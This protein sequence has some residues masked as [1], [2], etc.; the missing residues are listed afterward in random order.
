MKLLIINDYGING[1]GTE[2]RIKQLAEFLFNSH[3]FE[4]IHIIEH[5]T[6]NSQHL[7][8]Q[9]HKLN[10]KK[11]EEEIKKIII[12]YAI[13]HVQI[14]N[15]TL[16]PSKIIK[17]I[18]KY[19]LPIIF[20]AHDYWGFCGRRNLTTANQQICKGF[21]LT[22]CLPC[23]GVFSIIHLQKIKQALNL[24]DVGIAP[25]SYVQNIYENH[26]I[27]KNKWVI[28]PPW[29]DKEI[30][31][32]HKKQ[33]K[34]KVILFVG[35]L[36]YFK[37]IDLLLESISIIKDQLNQFEIHIVG[38][39]QDKDNKNRIRI[40]QKAKRIG[41]YFQLK[42]LGK[43]SL[44]ELAKEYALASVSVTCPLWP[45]V[46]GQTWAQALSCGTPVV[47]TKVGSIPEL[48]GKKVRLV[49][50]NATALANGILEEINNPVF[51]S[52][53]LEDFSLQ[54]NIPLLQKIY[55]DLMKNKPHKTL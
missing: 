34:Q 17:Q 16:F 51:P 12:K 14:H 48:A 20:F 54:K 35:P 39:S 5:E 22:H 11:A 7:F 36:D 50:P 3:F 32:N 4:E 15:M 31:L 23:I 1:S 49:E 55:T 21:Q 9:V 45:E 18:K 6:G 47:A 46:F 26:G 52:L 13:T 43:M 41:I 2:I 29:I 53:T 8:L 25:A 28:L 40:E 27:L 44:K 42:F 24:C 19:K 30:F 33:K 37:G 38:N 10:S